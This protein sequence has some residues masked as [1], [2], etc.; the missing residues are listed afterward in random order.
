MG[1]SKA[2]MRS[3]FREKDVANSGELDHCQM[4]Q[5]LQELRHEQA[6]DAK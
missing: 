5:V 4:L 2:Q 3:R 1:L 6:N